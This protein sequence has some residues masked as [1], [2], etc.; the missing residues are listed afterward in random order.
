MSASGLNDQERSFISDLF[1]SYGKNFGLTTMRELDN[2]AYNRERQWNRVEAEKDK[3]IAQLRQDLE[4]ANYKLRRLQTSHFKS[5]E[6]ESPIPDSKL[7][8]QYNTLTSEVKTIVFNL[9]KAATPNIKTVIRLLAQS[10]QYQDGLIRVLQP[11]VSI[12][13]FF[14]LLEKSD[15]PPKI[16]SFILRAIIMNMLRLKLFNSNVFMGIGGES[17]KQLRGVYRHLLAP[18]VDPNGDEPEILVAPGDDRLRKDASIWRSQTLITLDRNK[19]RLKLAEGRAVVV[20]LL[21]LNIEELLSPLA[22]SAKVKGNLKNDIRMLVEYAADLS[23]TLGRQRAMFELEPKRYIGHRLD[24]ANMEP[25]GPWAV[26]TDDD[27]PASGKCTDILAVVIPAL[28]KFGNDDGEEFERF[29]VVKAAQVLVLPS[30]DVEKAPSSVASSVSALDESFDVPS[31]SDEVMAGASSADLSSDK[32]DPPPPVAKDEVSDNPPTVP[33]KGEGKAD[34]ATK[35]DAQAA[36]ID[37]NKML[38]VEFA[39]APKARMS[40]KK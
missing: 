18:G 34:P 4:T 11:N 24:A 16:L 14:E 36:I 5:V 17:W 30:K 2:E 12:Q 32:N 22:E 29:R 25:V 9:T 6:R 38:A 13:Q 3:E 10:T 15:S 35:K 21:V 37:K 8:E 31:T 33:P 23:I 19:E 28:Y 7:G 1:K 27:D 40:S 39:I 20:N 26:D